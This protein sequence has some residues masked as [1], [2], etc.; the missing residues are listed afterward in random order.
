MPEFDLDDNDSAEPRIE[1][2]AVRLAEALSGVPRL[3]ILIPRRFNIRRSIYGVQPLLGGA[4]IQYSLPP[5]P[6]ELLLL[7]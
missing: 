7:G 4:L 6:S 2:K 3:A 5:H 1:K